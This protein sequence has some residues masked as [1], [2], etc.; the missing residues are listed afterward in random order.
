MNAPV[1]QWQIVTTDP[2]SLARFY[3]ELFGW[4][5]SKDNA[6]GYREIA[7]GSIKGGL[8]PAP[9]GAPSFVQLFVGVPDVEASVTKATAM[10]ATVIVPVTTLP[11]G[12]VM[13]VIADPMGVTFGLM[14]RP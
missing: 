9:A 4:T 3:G 1:M 6:L 13:A 12:A 10:G 7:T 8:W 5:I 11:D 14:R 2:E